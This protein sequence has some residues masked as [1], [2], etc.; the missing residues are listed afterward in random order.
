MVRSAYG[1]TTIVRLHYIPLSNSYQEIYN[2]HAFFSGATEATLRA[3]N[4]TTLDLSQEER[5]PTDGD[6]RLRRIARAGKQWR[7][8][9]GRKEDMEGK[10]SYPSLSLSWLIRPRSRHDLRS[11]HVSVVPRVR[12]TLGRR[13]RS[14]EL[15]ALS[16][17]FPT[18]AL[19]GA[20]H[21]FVP[22]K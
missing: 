18:L 10:P 21:G 11:L 4:T 20:P 19:T 5:K 9:F 22:P 7:R 17:I 1:G 15:L 6:R 2:I 12:E 14:D 13:S 8:T 16:P 3:A